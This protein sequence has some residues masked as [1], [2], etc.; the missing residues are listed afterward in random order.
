MYRAH[1]CLPVNGANCDPT[2]A[3]R[4]RTLIGWNGDGEFDRIFESGASQH[5]NERCE[6]LQAIMARATE[7]EAH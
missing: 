4:F 7:E 1:R 3:S 5:E 6:S 2:I